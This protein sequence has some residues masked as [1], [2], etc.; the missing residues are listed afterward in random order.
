MTD[1][2]SLKEAIEQYETQLS[3]V[4]ATLSTT[5]KGPYRD[6]L[7]SLKS[8]INELIFLTKESL[9]SLE[10]NVENTNEDPDDKTEDLLDK[11]YV[12]F[13]AELEK[14]SNDS[15]DEQDNKTVAASGSIEDELKELEGTKCK[16]PHGSTWGGIGYHN[17]MICSVYKD[18]S[19][20]IKDVHDI[21]ARVFFLNPTHKEMI[22]CPYFLNG[23]CKFSDENC[24]YCHGK[25]VPFSN[26][27]EYKEP[28]FHN[29]KIGSKVL[30]KQKNNMWY[31]SIVLKLPEKNGDEYRL[32]F[33]SSGQIV[34]AGLQDLFPLDDTNLE[35]SN[36]FNDS[37]NGDEDVNNDNELQ[38]NSYIN[39]QLVHKSLLTLQSNEPLGNWEKHTRGIGSKLMMQMGYV[40]G[41]GLGKR[42]D[43][44]IEPVETQILPAG[45]SLDYC[46]ELREF[47]GD[48]K[49][50]F[51]AERNMR[52]QQQKLEQQRERQYQKQKQKDDNDVFNFI[53]KALS[54]KP[55]EN[56]ASSLQSKDKLKTES[57]RNLNIASFQIGEHINRLEK[58]SSKLKESLTKHAKDSVFYNNIAMKYNEKQKELTNLRA[59]EKSIIAEQNQ[60]KN[61]VK[62]SIF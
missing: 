6:N 36:T 33:E 12:F 15:K 19:E 52:K 25:I 57:N 58:E 41:T 39:N 18:S 1:A 21:K 32:K 45:K 34:E 22:P 43:G 17:A 44:R 30:T 54:D 3:Q 37:N 48:D 56:L 55:E 5:P 28:D 49:D 7:L 40:I 60:R 4:D 2:R 50:L 42:S 46:M 31:R 16:A 14:S 47:A 38:P 20:V 62:L 27:Q 53:N 29:I 51:S 24:H 61:K 10:E 23:S 26:L 11:E 59:S 13:K 9:Q 35:M 8:D